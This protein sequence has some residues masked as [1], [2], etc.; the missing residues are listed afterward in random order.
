MSLKDLLKTNPRH[1]ASDKKGKAAFIDWDI[2]GE[3]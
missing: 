2:D 1:V 3:E